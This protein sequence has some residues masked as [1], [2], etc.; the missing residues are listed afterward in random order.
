MQLSPLKEC[1]V[2]HGI[3]QCCCHYKI[4]NKNSCHMPKSA[5]LFCRGKNPRAGNTKMIAGKL[6]P[7]W[8]HLVSIPQEIKGSKRA[9]LTQ[10]SPSVSQVQVQKRM[11]SCPYL[12]STS[13]MKIKIYSQL[14]QNIFKARWKNIES[15]QKFLS[16]WMSIRGSTETNR[17]SK[18]DICGS[19]RLCAA[20]LG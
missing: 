1:N 5:W 14:N 12:T 2:T 8:G 15:W 13:L 16:K 4:R 7:N 19:N 20:D 10:M 17:L 9:N 3:R 6:F 18:V 11:F